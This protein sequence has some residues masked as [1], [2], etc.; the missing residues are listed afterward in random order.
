M[1]VESHVGFPDHSRDHRFLY[2]ICQKCIS[3]DADIIVGIFILP[4]S[5]SIT[6]VNGHIYQKTSTLV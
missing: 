3:I 4:I 6:I 5:G 1:D 2:I